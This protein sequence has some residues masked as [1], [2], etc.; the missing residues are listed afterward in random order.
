MARRHKPQGTRRHPGLPPM[1][2]RAAGLAMGATLPVIAVPP[3]LAPAPGRTLRSFPGALHRL[4]DWCVA[5]GIT[6]VAMESTGIYGMPVFASL[7]ARG[8]E[9]LR[10]NAR[11][12]KKVPGRKTDGK[13]AQ[14]RQP[15]HQY[16]RLRGSGRPAQAWA[17]LRAYLGQREGVVEYA[18]APSQHRQKARMQRPRQVHPVVADIPGGT[19]RKRMRAIVA[20]KHAPAA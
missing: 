18:A 15:R 6:T 13:D 16:G 12:G 14:W 9:V 5:L 1:P 11:Q 7:E 2:P 10:V 20:G 8:R 17:A 4:A 3:D 19:G